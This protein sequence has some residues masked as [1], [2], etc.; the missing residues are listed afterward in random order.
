[1]SDGWAGHGAL[2]GWEEVQGAQEGRGRARG[3]RAVIGR[4]GRGAKMQGG[5]HGAGIKIRQNYQS[6][7]IGLGVQ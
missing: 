2:C 5:E 3:A 6:L 4:P 1:M 7:D